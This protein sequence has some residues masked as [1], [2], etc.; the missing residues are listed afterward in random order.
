M[1]VLIV[2]DHKGLQS[3]LCDICR[4]QGWEARAIGDGNGVV[5]AVK[6]FGPD[7][8]L[9]DLWLPGAHGRAV[10]DELRAGPDPSLPVIVMSVTPDELYPRTTADSVLTKPFDIDELVNA[11]QRVVPA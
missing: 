9:L 4:M 1:K 2:D 5:Q 10:L 8:V 3:V 6:E 7:V 11:I